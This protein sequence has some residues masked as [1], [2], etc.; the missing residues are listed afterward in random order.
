M[1]NRKMILE[2]ALD[3]FYARGYDA[4]GVQEVAERSGVTKPTLYYYFKSKYGL[5][6]Q[7]LESR[8]EPFMERLHKACAYEGDLRNTLCA[9][10]GEL[11]S[12]AKQEPKFYTLFLALYHSAKENEAYQAVR[13]LV[14]RLQQEIEQIFVS[15][16]GILG[17]MH[18]RQRQFSLGFIGLIL[19]DIKM[20]LE[21]N[22]GLRMTISQ[23]EIHSLVHQF[24]HGI[25][26]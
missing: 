15:A 2:T 1:D 22:G 5:L 18:G 23:E 7:L 20:K 14:I 17:N 10:A 12:F 25:Y 16:A 21:V 9:A 3:L 11:A 24:M 8:G 13:P 19:Y 6:E 26:S 4:V